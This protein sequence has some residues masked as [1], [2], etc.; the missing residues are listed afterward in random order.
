MFYSLLGA[1]IAA[2]TRSWFIG[3]NQPF[4]HSIMGLPASRQRHIL[5]HLQPTLQQRAEDFELDPNEAVDLGRSLLFRQ[6]NT[7]SGQITLV[8]GSGL[9]SCG[10]TGN[11]LVWVLGRG[12]RLLLE[13]Q[14]YKI[15]IRRSTHYGFPDIV[16]SSSWTADGAQFILYRFDG[17]KYRALTCATE[18]GEFLGK[19]LPRPRLEYGPCDK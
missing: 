17:L 8:Q 7:P 19:V 13:G 15:T 14:A 16:T 6:I 2:Q 1:P 5:Q 10:G 12:D 18:R 4:P 3:D 9:N 11:C